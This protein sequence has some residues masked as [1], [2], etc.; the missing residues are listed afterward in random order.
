MPDNEVQLGG[1]FMMEGNN[2]LRV[3]HLRGLGKLWF[4]DLQNFWGVYFLDYG[5]V[6]SNIHEFR[7]KDI[8]VGAGIGIRY[9]TL[10]G[11]VRLD[12]GFRVYDP[13]EFLGKEWF[14]KKKFFKEVI[15][16]GVLNFG[17]GHAF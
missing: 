9:D 13:K 6:W 15:N 12:F 14:F 8:A 16:S 3:N 10:L 7:I 1:N 2:E 4:L 17:I 11:P 5:N